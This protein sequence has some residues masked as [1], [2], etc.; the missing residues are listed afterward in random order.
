MLPGKTKIEIPL[1]EVLIDIGGQG[2]PKDIYPLVTKKFPQ[3]SEED[4]LRTQPSGANKWTNTIQWT[5]L[6][7]VKKGDM[8]GPSR[9]IWAITDLGRKRV[10]DKEPLEERERNMHRRAI[11]KWVREERSKLGAVLEPEILTNKVNLN[12]VLPKTIWLKENVKEI[13]GL[14]RLK[15]GKQIFYQSVLEVQ[16]KGS[17]E[18][19]CVRVSIILPFVTRVDIVSDE[20]SIKKI[21]EFL[22]RLC[23]PNIVKSRVKFYSFKKFLKTN[24]LSELQEAIRRGAEGLE[25]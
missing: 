2:K 12:E 8:F 7:L 9:G 6:R 20:Q 18:D 16:Y 23:D 3:I 24:L 13:D 4:L 10:E 17:K 22:N 15:I 11:N 19:L 1:L 5:R 14:A 25:Y 21:R